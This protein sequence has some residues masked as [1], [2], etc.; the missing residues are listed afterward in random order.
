M[1]DIFRAYRPFLM[2][3]GKFLLSYLILIVLY[4]WYLSQFDQ[5]AFE[6][7]GMTHL[8]AEQVKS[9]LSFFDYSISLRPY[10]K[11]ASILVA[12][13]GRSVVRIIEGCNAISVMILFAA[14]I[15]SF[16]RTFA[17][18]L[19]FI[20]LGVILIHILNVLRIVLLIIGILKLPQYEHLLHGV[21]FPLI[22]YGFVFLLWVIWV[23]K[24]QSDA[25]KNLRS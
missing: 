9:V 16:S 18:T 22:I 10:S 11:D 23:N 7:D 2:F 8:V 3:L 14:F 5:Q 25:K 4:Q 13:D 20:V 6:V 1:K 24:F 15:V 12:V 17:K 19:G 21:V